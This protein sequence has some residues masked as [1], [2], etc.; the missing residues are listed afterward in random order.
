VLHFAIYKLN[1]AFE[2]HYNT[3]YRFEAFS[4]VVVVGIIGT[5]SFNAEVLFTLPFELAVASYYM[6]KVGISLIH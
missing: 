6:S 1:F 4:L 2:I 5:Y 3:K